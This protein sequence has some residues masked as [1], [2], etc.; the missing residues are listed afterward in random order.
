MLGIGSSCL[1]ARIQYRK[2][3]EL[4]ANS[5]ID[6]QDEIKEMEDMMI[7]IE[8]I[9]CSHKKSISMLSSN[10]DIEALTCI[11]NLTNRATIIKGDDDI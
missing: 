11:L 7:K 1:Q 4:D 6:I 9:Q 8:S 10:N 3:I 2:A 5:N